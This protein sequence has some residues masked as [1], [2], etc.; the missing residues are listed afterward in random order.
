MMLMAI[1]ERAMNAQPSTQSVAKFV[2]EFSQA[3]LK[4]TAENAIATPLQAIGSPQGTT[5]TLLRYWVSK[6]SKVLK[7]LHRLFEMAE[8]SDNSMIQKM[9][10]IAETTVATAVDGKAMKEAMQTVVRSLGM[11]YEA[12]LLSKEPE[13]GRLAETLKPQLLVLMQDPT[14]SANVT[15]SCRNSCH[16]DEWYPS[17]NPE[18]MAFN[19]NSSCKFRLIFSGSGLI[20]HYSGMEG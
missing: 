16:A 4:V 6:Y 13:I 15:R 2:Q 19:I 17:Y 14:V 3:L 20:Q 7:S 1:V 10:Q 18:K 12:G 11:N 9:V 8:R 5:N